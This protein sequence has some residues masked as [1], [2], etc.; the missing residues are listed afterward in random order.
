MYDTGITGTYV[1]SAYNSVLAQTDSTEAKKL[2]DEESYVCLLDSESQEIESSGGSDHKNN[3]GSHSLD[4]TVLIHETLVAFA[5]GVNIAKLNA[6]FLKSLKYVLTVTASIPV[7]IL[8]GLVIGAAP[9][10]FGFL[11]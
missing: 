5:L 10:I 11:K 2:E 6:G 7:G 1:Q 8:L 4:K 3:E 9:G